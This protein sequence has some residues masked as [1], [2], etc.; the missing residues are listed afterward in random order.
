MHVR[1]WL[2]G[3]SNLHPVSVATFVLEARGNTDLSDVYETSRTGTGE[4]EEF[5]YRGA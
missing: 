2:N 3:G 5:T 4:K 1:L